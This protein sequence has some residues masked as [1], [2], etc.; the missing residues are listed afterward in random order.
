MQNE[1]FRANKCKW[2]ENAVAGDRTRVTRVTGG[3]THHYTTTPDLF[4][5][6]NLI[7]FFVSFILLSV[8]KKL[9][10]ICENYEMN[11]YIIL[12]PK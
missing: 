11:L 4:V 5:G 10:Y 3:N 7:Y 1:P 2:K 8:I 6:R 9:E 12:R